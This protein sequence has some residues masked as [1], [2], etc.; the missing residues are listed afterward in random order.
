MSTFPFRSWRPGGKRGLQ[1]SVAAWV[2]LSHRGSAEALE[3]RL[4]SCITES[5]WE[6]R[7]G[8]GLGSAEPPRV[9]HSCLS[10]FREMQR[11]HPAFAVKR[12]SFM[13]PK[14]RAPARNIASLL[15]RA[16]A[17]NQQLFLSKGSARCCRT[18]SH[19]L[20][21]R[22]G[23]RA[24]RGPRA[25]RDTPR[26]SVQAC[27]ALGVPRAWATGCFLGACGPFAHLSCV[28]VMEGTCPCPGPAPHL[29]RCAPHIRLCSVSLCKPEHTAAVKLL[30]STP[31]FIS[32]RILKADPG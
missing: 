24:P 3:G 27:G 32:P 22:A 17:F 30:L 7:H 10:C 21:A 12:W 23:G 6:R 8:D 9:A 5:L 31:L 16:V 20:W 25:D 4:L 29:Q 18:S 1:R 2:L 13:R 11:R 15:C 19:W 14:P 28:R 26:L